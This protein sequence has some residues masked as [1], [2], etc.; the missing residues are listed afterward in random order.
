MHN[1]F[2]T[3]NEGCSSSGFVKEFVGENTPRRPDLHMVRVKAIDPF[4]VVITQ[5]FLTFVI[6]ILCWLM[7]TT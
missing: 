2:E 5:M 6:L 4:Y 7:H 1:C 3:G